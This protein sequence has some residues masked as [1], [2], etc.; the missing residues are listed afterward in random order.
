M[1]KD[2]KYRIIYLKKCIKKMIS[3]LYLIINNKAKTKQKIFKIL[4]L[5]IYKIIV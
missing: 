5:H 2:K 4:N 1:N 3:Q